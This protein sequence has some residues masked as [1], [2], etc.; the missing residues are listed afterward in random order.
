MIF[1]RVGVLL[2]MMPVVFSI[3]RLNHLVVRY[4]QVRHQIFT[5]QHLPCLVLLLR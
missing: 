4:I 5:K 3:L 1:G 2:I